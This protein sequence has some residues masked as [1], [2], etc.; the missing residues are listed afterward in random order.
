LAKES[1]KSPKVSNPQE[2]TIKTKMLVP[3]CNVIHALPLGDEVATKIEQQR[4]GIGQRA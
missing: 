3:T 1:Y 2:T 4:A